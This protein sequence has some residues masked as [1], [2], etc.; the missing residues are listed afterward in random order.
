M[1][2]LYYRRFTSNL[3][4]GASQVR[5]EQ[6]KQQQKSPPLLKPPPDKK[7]PFPLLAL[8][9]L[10]SKF[11]EPYSPSNNYRSLRHYHLQHFPSEAPTSQRFS[12][13]GDGIRHITMIS[14]SIV[15]S[16][17]QSIL[18]A[19]FTMYLASP[20]SKGVESWHMEVSKD[21]LFRPF[22]PH[23][24]D[25]LKTL[26]YFSS[27]LP[28]FL[29]SWINKPFSHPYEINKTRNLIISYYNWFIP[30]EYN[31]GPMLIPIITSNCILPQ[32]TRKKTKHSVNPGRAIIILECYD[33]ITYLFLAVQRGE[34]STVSQYTDDTSRHPE[35]QRI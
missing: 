13:E 33:I 34:Y 29:H 8:H 24:D 5:Q 23:P 9:H 2:T 15:P 32:E 16:Q 6:Q 4:A 21:C 18:T 30:T 25:F 20:P 35:A 26:S 22:Q 10:L 17:Q 7:K 27:F 28:P 12:I 3:Q 14:R 31:A 11:I 1:I 19:P